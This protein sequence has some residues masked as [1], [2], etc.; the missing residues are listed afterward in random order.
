MLGLIILLPIIGSLFFFGVENEDQS[1]N[2]TIIARRNSIIKQIGL[3]TSLITLLLVLFLF[4]QMNNNVGGYQF[5]ETIIP[6][7]FI[8]LDGISIYYVLLTA[9]ITPIAL[10]SN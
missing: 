1:V 10:L 3:A 2:N 6:F 9:F 4:S 5:A 7:G 8:A